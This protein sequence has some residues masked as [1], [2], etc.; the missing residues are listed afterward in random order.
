[1]DC[2]LAYWGQ[3]KRQKG[4]RSIQTHRH[5]QIL[6]HRQDTAI[7]WFGSAI[8]LINNGKYERVC[9]CGGACA[10]AHVT[11]CNLL[12]GSDNGNFYERTSITPDTD[13]A[14]SLISLMSVLS[15]TSSESPSLITTRM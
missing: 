11:F 14:H 13:K 9:V 15:I 8:V 6:W 4:V 1:M 10:C 3:S 12:E 5:Y 7:T 2:V